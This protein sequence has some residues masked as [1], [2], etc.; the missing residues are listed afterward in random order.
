MDDFIPVQVLLTGTLGQKA[1]KKEVIAEIV[2]VQITTSSFSSLT[3][4]ILNFVLQHC[5]VPL[6]LLGQVNFLS[7]SVE[8]SIFK[9]GIF[10]LIHFKHLIFYF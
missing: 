10:L 2:T 1:D 3:M 8:G 4:V 9:E 7:C 6:C 5:K